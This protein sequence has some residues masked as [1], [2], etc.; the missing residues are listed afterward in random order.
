MKP[1]IDKILAFT[2][3]KKLT[4][5]AIACLFVFLDKI[6]NT[7]WVNIAI[8]YIGTQ[9]VADIIKDLRHK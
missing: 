2:I 7:Q 9:G 8:M 6:D 4:V 3:S 1:I 5:F